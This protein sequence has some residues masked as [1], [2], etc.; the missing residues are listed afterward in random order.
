M[1]HEA[2]AAAVRERAAE[3]VRAPVRPRRE[4]LADQ[5]AARQ[6]LD[7]VEASL[8]A[9]ARRLAVGLDHARDVVLVHLLGKAAVE[10][11]AHGRGCD[12]RQPIGRV[13]LAAPAEMGDLAHQGRTVPVYALGELLQVGND[14]VHADVELA[15]DIGRVGRHVRGAAEH[16]ERDAAFRLLLVVELIAL[17]RHAAFLEPAGVARA[18]QPVL[19]HERFDRERSEEGVLRASSVRRRRALLDVHLLG[20]L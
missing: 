19:E 17:L 14:G 12:R 3:A 7:A 2:E 10:R 20:S 1:H 13:G 16:R 5:V 4:E 8:L 6:R 18:H 15:E 9:A 11:L